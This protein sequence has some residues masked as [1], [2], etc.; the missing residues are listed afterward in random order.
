M[1]GKR[2]TEKRLREIK[3]RFT[4]SEF[5]K[6]MEETGRSG[7]SR[8]DFCRRILAGAKVV[9][10]HPEELSEA[11]VLLRSAEDTVIR[12]A[13]RDRMELDAEAAEKLLMTLY[14]AEK[15]IAAYCG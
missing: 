14:E 6:L 7:L 4:D 15:N 1:R 5:D 3:V 12:A 2:N 10:A 9:P 11:I 8:E 13:G